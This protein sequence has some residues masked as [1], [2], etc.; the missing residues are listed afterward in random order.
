MLTPK[1]IV[2]QKQQLERILKEKWFAHS[3]VEKWLENL[4]E[5]TVMDL[6]DLKKGSFD[7]ELVEIMQADQFKKALYMEL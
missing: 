7:Y 4:V 5:Q 2:K 6:F 1:H 3:R